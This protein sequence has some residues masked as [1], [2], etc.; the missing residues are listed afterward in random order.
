MILHQSVFECVT[1]KL[2]ST[3]VLQAAPPNMP[4]AAAQTIRVKD[5]CSTLCMKNKYPVLR[6]IVNK[7]SNIVYYKYAVCHHGKMHRK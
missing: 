7:I 4:P 2:I 1:P 5:A 6:I 3:R